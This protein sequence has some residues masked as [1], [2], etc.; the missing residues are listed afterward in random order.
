M[1][2]YKQCSYSLHKAIKQAKCRYRDKVES[3]SN[4]SDMR[5]MWQGLQETTD[6]KKKTSHVTDTDVMLPDKLNTFFVHFE[7]NTV[8]LSRPANKNC[9]PPLSVPVADVSKT[10]KR[11]NPRK[12]AGPD[13]IPS[14]VLRECADQLAGVW[15]G[16]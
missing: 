6:Y 12:A 2:E 13:G 16:R 7:D 9:A 3:Q 4:G 14:C 8:P 11:F 5:R 10:F 1:A 15:G